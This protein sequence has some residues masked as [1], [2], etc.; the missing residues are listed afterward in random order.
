MDD[1]MVFRISSI[2]INEF[3]RANLRDLAVLSPKTMNVSSSLTSDL[4]GEVYVI[5]PIAFMLRG[6]NPLRE[7]GISTIKLLDAV[8]LTF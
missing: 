5:F 1:E 7:T 2:R 8:Y 6:L 3:S 4:N